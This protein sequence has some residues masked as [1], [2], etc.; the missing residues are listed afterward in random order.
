MEAG[1]VRT[2]VGCRRKRR[3]DELLR[4][5]RTPD[6]GTH[7]DPDGRGAGR[8][9]YICFDPACVREAMS[10][11]RLRRGLRLPGALSEGLEE[12]ILR[13]IDARRRATE[14]GIDG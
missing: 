1:P 10:S 6:G 11:G 4:V 2:C 7:A 5:V 9:A 12:E 8:G 14:R 13:A 3:K